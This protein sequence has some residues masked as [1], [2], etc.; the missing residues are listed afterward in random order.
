M[1]RQFQQDSLMGRCDSEKRKKK[2]P[3]RGSFVARSNCAGWVFGAEEADPYL[4]ARRDQ[5]GEEAALPDRRGEAVR[6]DGRNPFRM[7]VPVA[8]AFGHSSVG[9][10]EQLH[11]EWQIYKLLPACHESR[12]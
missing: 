11:T 4:P 6:A 7:D 2:S 12:W 8:R 5:T 10:E 3:D 1:H 9:E